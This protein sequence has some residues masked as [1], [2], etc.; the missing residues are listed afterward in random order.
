MVKNITNDFFNENVYNVKQELSEQSGEL[1]F[2]GKKPVL[3][4]FYA[5]WCGPCRALEP[6]LE[7]LSEEYKDKIDIYKVNTETETETA[8]AFGIMGLPTLLF[9]PMSDKPSISP[10]APSKDMLKE[11]IDEK[12]L[13]NT[14]ELKTQVSKFQ[15]MMNTIKKALT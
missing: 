1:K 13:G 6:M 9:I 14:S 7:E 5:T 8:V 4:D 11:M 12:L 2:L 15:Q 3:V 10:G